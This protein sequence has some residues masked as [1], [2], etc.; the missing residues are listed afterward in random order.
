MS[1]PG[2]EI[3]FAP[4]IFFLA[5]TNRAAVRAVVDVV[6]GTDAVPHRGAFEHCGGGGPGGPPQA[7]APAPPTFRQSAWLER[8]VRLFGARGHDA[9]AAAK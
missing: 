6:K 9:D 3:G 2:A 1:T 4:A 7:R 8:I 5:G